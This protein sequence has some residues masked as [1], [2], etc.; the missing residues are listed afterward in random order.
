[1]KLYK[2][3]PAALISGLLLIGLSA[4]EKEPAEKAGD[5]IEEAASDV[6]ESAEEAAEAIKEKME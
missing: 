1:M 2:A 3:I 5:A 4:C 6:A